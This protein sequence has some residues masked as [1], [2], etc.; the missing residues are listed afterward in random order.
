MRILQRE[1]NKALDTIEIF[2]TLDEAKKLSGIL[3][4][5]VEHPE[6]GHSHLEADL[7]GNVFQKEL[8]V[9]IYTDNNLDEF[10]E[11]SKKLILEDK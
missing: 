5:M 3:K 11:R 2:L 7:V 9:A 4:H 8:T 10:D 6:S 1:T